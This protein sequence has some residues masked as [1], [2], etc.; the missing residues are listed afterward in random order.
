[1]KVINILLIIKIIYFCTG[2]IHQ[3][4]FSQTTKQYWEKFPNASAH[5]YE[6][7]QFV[8]ILLNG[9]KLSYSSKELLIKTIQCR[10]NLLVDTNSF[11]VELDTSIIWKFE[12]LLKD[13]LKNN[14]TLI[15]F[16]PHVNINFYYRQYV[17]FHIN[18]NDYLFVGFHTS[19]NLVSD[20]EKAYYT[21]QKDSFK[22]CLNK[23]D[24]TI[25]SRLFLSHHYRWAKYDYQFFVLYEIGSGKMD[26]IYFESKRKNCE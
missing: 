6:N 2:V 5:Y 14:E 20:E 3:S 12:K 17:R 9:N 19:D 23:L 16:Q 8:G 1:M 22:V 18:N 10:T 11:I 21:H 26:F 15:T 4:V 7:E 13:T 25:S 24:T